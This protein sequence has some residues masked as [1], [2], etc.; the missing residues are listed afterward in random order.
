MLIFI[1]FTE[2]M[3]FNWDEYFSVS[4]KE[5]KEVLIDLFTIKVPLINNGNFF[6]IPISLIEKKQCFFEEYQLLHQVNQEK[7]QT[8]IKKYKKI[9][10]GQNLEKFSI[11]NSVEELLVFFEEIYP[12][13]CE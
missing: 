9:L 10:G 1:L 8:L 13:I 2:S 3:S 11:E 5:V 12:T 6:R 4:R 7:I